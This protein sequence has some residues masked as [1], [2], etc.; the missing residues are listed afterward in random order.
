M[1][2]HTVER[3]FWEFGNKPARIDEFLAD[4]DTYLE[5]YTS[6]TADE[7]RMIKGVDLKRLSDHGVSNMLTMMVWP[8][9]KG[10]DGMPFDYLT[11]MNAGRLPDMGLPPLKAAGLKTY[12]RFRNA[13]AQFL[14]W[15][16]KRRGEDPRGDTSPTF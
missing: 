9:L 13:R 7:R 4:P 1:S 8:M 2:V 6:L 12:I 10:A 5:R 15:R 14:R 3:V 11:H 16:R